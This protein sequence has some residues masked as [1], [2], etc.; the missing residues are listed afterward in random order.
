MEFKKGDI[1]V[2]KED[3]LDKLTKNNSYVIFNI[4]NGDLTGEKIFR[5][6]CDNKCM[7][8]FYSKRFYDIKEYRDYI[9]D[10]LSE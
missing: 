9:I 8:N 10:N 6:L 7:Y 5:L 3:Y 2:A 1:V 4:K